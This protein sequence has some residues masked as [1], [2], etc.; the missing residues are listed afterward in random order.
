MNEDAKRITRL[1]NALMA[2]GLP[3]TDYQCDCCNK[4][5]IKSSYEDV[6]CWACCYSCKFDAKTK[7][8]I[9]GNWCP[10]IKLDE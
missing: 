2:A 3:Y 9:K 6:R 7:Q 8:W 4:I 10:G 5:Y 1:E